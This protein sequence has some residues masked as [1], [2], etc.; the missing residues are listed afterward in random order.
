MSREIKFRVWV[1]KTKKFEYLPLNAF[2]I[3]PNIGLNEYSVAPL[4]AGLPDK[5][6]VIQQFTGLLDIN[7]KEIFEGDIVDIRNVPFSRYGTFTSC[8]EVVFEYG[9]FRLKYFKSNETFIDFRPFKDLI[10]TI[11]SEEAI[12]I[13]NIFE[14]P[15]LLTK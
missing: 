13:G 2:Y 1:P 11:A 15:E 4:F 3:L 10:N 7:G 5:E 6:A 12:I 8:F 9:K 14:N